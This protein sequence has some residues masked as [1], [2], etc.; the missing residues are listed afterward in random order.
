MTG[1]ST[2]KI[3]K[4][5]NFTATHTHSAPIT[6]NVSTKEK[7]FSSSLTLFEVNIA[8][9]VIRKAVDPDANVIFG[10]VIDE[11]MH[12]KIRITVVATGFERS[13][14]R[15]HMVE[16]REVQETPAAK[17][18]EPSPPSPTKKQT[19]QSAWARPNFAQNDL[20]IPAFLRRR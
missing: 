11:N 4:T 12:N 17:R 16:R 18:S 14:P 7:A 2:N 5:S 20:A 3:H 1:I 13:E 10:A 15:Q 9:E 8:A 19:G 6:K